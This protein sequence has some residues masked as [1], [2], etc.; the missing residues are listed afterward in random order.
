LDL[1]FRLLMNYPVAYLDRV[2][3]WYR[4]HEGNI[5]KNEELR[6]TENIRVIK[7]LLEQFPGAQRELGARR[8]AKRISYRYYRLAKKRWHNGRRDNARE[9]IRES[10]SLRPFSLKYRLYQLRW[11]ATARATEPAELS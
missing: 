2:V 1:S 10:I 9:A 6:L 5:G 4:F 8:V 3:F 11:G 7:K